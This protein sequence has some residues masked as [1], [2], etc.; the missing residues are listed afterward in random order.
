MSRKRLPCETRVLVKANHVE[1][2]LNRREPFFPPLMTSWETQS[3][4]S[5]FSK[6][7]ANWDGVPC[8]VI[9]TKVVIHDEFPGCRIEAGMTNQAPSRNSLIMSSR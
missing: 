7:N 3:R 9:P 2:R 6:I 8:C 4:I 1:G 5:P